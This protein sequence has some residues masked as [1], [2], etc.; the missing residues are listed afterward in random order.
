MVMM[1]AMVQEDGDDDDHAKSQ[2]IRD[3]LFP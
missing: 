3:E 1:I 2:M